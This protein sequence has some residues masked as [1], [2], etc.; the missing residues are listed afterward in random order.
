MEFDCLVEKH[1]HTHT[2]IYT[3]LWNSEFGFVFFVGFVKIVNLEGN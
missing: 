3:V 1:T 2:H